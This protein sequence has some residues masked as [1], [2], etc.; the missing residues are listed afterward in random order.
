MLIIVK[1][2]NLIRIVTNHHVI[3]GAEEINIFTDDNEPIHFDI[4]LSDKD[5]DIAIIKMTREVPNVFPLN[6]YRLEK[7][8][9]L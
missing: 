4:E 2:E 9:Q 6:L 8:A 7:N 3:D 1:H 5:K